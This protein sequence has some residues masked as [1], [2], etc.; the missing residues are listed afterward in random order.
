MTTV[1]SS[2]L[3]WLRSESTADVRGFFDEI[4]VNVPRG[5]G[6]DL[7][8]RCFAN[9]EAHTHGDR[10]KS[11]VLNMVTGLWCCHGCGRSG[12]AYQAAMEVGID[13]P[14][15]RALAQRYGLFLE[16][17]KPEKQKLPGERQLKKWR[18]ALRTSESLLA[19]LWEV[20]GWTLKAIWRCGLGWDGERITFP[21]RNHKLKLVGLVRYLPGGK[22]KSLALP[23]SKRL[24]FPAPEVTSKHRPLFVV[25]GEPDAVAVWSCGHQAVAIPGAGSWRG[26]FAL[27]LSGR[28]VIALSDC[29]SQ[30]RELA[31]KVAREVPKAKWVDVEPGRD[32]K[33]DI[34]DM[35]RGAA[36]E[37]GLRQMRDLLERLAK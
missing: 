22:P 24:L 7:N 5:T 16:V 28:R 11:C 17:A 34:G 18:H 23:G 12:N 27:R 9:P 30:G 8:V 1:A 25:E 26:E 2:E 14:R 21:I 36:R 33:Y 31:A 4:G 3:D 19:R 10:D 37:G 20:R 15:A 29:D 13:E 35:V 6:D 32:D